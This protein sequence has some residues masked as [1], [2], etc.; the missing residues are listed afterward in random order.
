MTFIELLKEIHG[1][2]KKHPVRLGT[3]TENAR[4]TT[5]KRFAALWFGFP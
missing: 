1:V 3:D 2:R 5:S 4:I